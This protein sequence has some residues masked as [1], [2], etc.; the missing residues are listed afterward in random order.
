[1]AANFQG[2]WGYDAT[3]KALH[4]FITY[5]SDGQLICYEQT[6]VFFE[7]NKNVKLKPKVTVGINEKGNY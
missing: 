7:T 5:R 3:T 1:M 2:N 6:N 4:S